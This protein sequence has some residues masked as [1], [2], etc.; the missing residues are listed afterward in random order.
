MYF[1]CK[2]RVTIADKILET[3]SAVSVD[4]DSKTLGS[5][6]DLVV[7]LNSRIQYKNGKHDFLTDQTR[8]LFKTGDPINVVA[9]YEG[10]HEVT[11]FDG[12]VVDFAEGTPMKI[13]CSDQVYLLNLSIIDVHYASVTLKALAEK[14]LAGTGITLATP[15]ID[16]TL[17]DITFKSMTPAAIF[18]WIKD[19]IGL[20]IS[21]TGKSLYIN[22]ASNTLNTVE[23][24]TTINVIGSDLQKPATL[25]LKLKLKAWFI[26]EN[27]TKD[28][29][30]VGDENGQ[31]REVFFY[32]L[33]QNEANYKKL[34]N[35][36]LLKYKQ[37]RYNGT[38][39]LLL[40]PEI[41]L[42]DQV[43]YKDFRY[44]EKNANYV[45]V[46]VDYDLA[47]NGFH[48]KIKLSYLSDII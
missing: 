21:L 22:V 45:A 36:A 39:E 32:K 33:P 16:L 7:P 44:P 41:S 28:S 34:A 26:R 35:E 5:N 43:R 2:L 12:F 24:D 8:N 30:E 31:L 40:Y 38:V 25:F 37:Y 48:R 13:K 29:F 20:N 11:V 15:T 3:V 19:Q 18:Q 46:G 17:Q 27:G 10:L 47:E 14:L 1:D 42:F 9:W 4:N 6:C 23:L